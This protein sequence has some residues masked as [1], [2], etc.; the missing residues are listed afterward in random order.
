MSANGYHER[1]LKVPRVHTHRIE[2]QSTVSEE[3]GISNCED[4]SSESFRSVYLLLKPDIHQEMVEEVTTKPMVWLLTITAPG[5]RR[6][7]NRIQG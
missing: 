5:H 1:P 4:C 3:M 6:P 2:S 7:V